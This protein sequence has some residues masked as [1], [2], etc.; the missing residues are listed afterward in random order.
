MAETER[1]AEGRRENFSAQVLQ[2]IDVLVVWC[3]FWIALW[4]RDPVFDLLQSIAGA[5]GIGFRKEPM[6]EIDRF[7]WMI[8]I[9][10]PFAPIV[11]ERF[12]FYRSPLRRSVQRTIW[13]LLRGLAVIGFVLMLLAIFLQW[14]V[15][16]RLAL[17][18]VVLLTFLLL[19]GR[20]LVVRSIVGSRARAGGAR[21][22]VVLA[23]NPADIADFLATLPEEQSGLWTVV[24]T[25]DPESEDWDGLR[26][27]LNEHAVERVV[28]AVEHTGFALVS[29]AIE[30]CEVQG[31]EAWLAADFIRTRIARPT[32]D[33]I[34]GRPMLVLRS[35]PE[36]SWALL[37]KSVIDRG[38]AA[39]L[40]LLSAP[41]W[42]AV[43]IG[44]KIQSP[45]PVFYFQERAGRYGRPFRMWKFR[46]MVPDADKKLEELKQEA[47]NQMS[48]P[49]FKLE[50]DPRIF[51]LGRIIRR[52]S[53]DELPQL[54]NVLLGDMSLVG[55]R[56]MALYEVH[57]I[58]RSEQR[59]KLSV[60]PGLTCIWQV[61][62]RNEITDFDEWVQLDLQYIDNWSLWLDFKILLKTVP[63]V[64]FAKG[65]K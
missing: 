59:R 51:P 43:A 15:P 19:L 44:I 9:A 20:D 3:A 35:T 65:A 27:L 63:T 7:M 23:G 32:F 58:Q 33:T 52:F 46:S 61:S 1:M 14:P 55:P 45:G 42:L 25:F 53:I 4:T 6:E 41:L 54:I 17:A 12:G 10:A 18:N 31:V 64:L 30:I 38:A 57:K 26:A 16:S 56:P 8:L 50:N 29:R 21:E 34:G 22:A 62:G 37:L 49:V 47:G 24:G 5:F 13:Q 36:L 48:G 11:L 60:K 28:F 39:V 40:L 2:L